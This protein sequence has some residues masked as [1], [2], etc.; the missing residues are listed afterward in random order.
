MFVIQ[1][2]SFKIILDTGDLGHYA[3]GGA[4]LG[5]GLQHYATHQEVAD[6]GQGQEGDYEQQQEHG[7]GEYEQSDEHQ[8]QY[9]H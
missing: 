3:E 5:H 6:Y 2:I 7:G 1:Q 8:L 9:H 4:D